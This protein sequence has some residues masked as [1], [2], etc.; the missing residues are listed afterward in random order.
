MLKKI[1][2]K[3]RFIYYILAGSGS[4]MLVVRSGST[5]VKLIKSKE[6]NKVEK[7]ERI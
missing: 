7:R 1:L 4:D 5:P 6:A 2:L 3:G